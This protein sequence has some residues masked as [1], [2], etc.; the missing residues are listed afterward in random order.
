MS[1]VDM[2]NEE[3]EE[4]RKHHDALVHMAE[5]ELQVEHIRESSPAA[6]QQKTLKPVE[7]QMKEL[8]EEIAR[9]SA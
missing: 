8:D 4:I 1:F 2:T 9:L 7:Q 3:W 5:L 6:N